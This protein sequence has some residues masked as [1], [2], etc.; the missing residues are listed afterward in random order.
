M[1]AVSFDGEKIAKYKI[2]NI[3]IAMRTP[4]NSRNFLNP[5]S[6]IN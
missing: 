6:Y 3:T 2:I 5:D 1:K 4:V